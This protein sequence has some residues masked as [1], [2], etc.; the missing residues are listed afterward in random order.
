MTSPVLAL[1]AAIRAICAG[2]GA[3]AELMDPTIH[4]EAPRGDPP[5][6]ATFGDVSLRDSSTS[7]ESGHEQDFEILVWA[8]PGSAA[9][10]LAASDRIATLLDD[11]SPALAGHR[12]VA[13][14]ARA[15]EAERDAASR[16]TRIALN[17]RALT[18]VRA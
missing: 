16:S 15:M 1:R 13:L 8:K 11:A 7:T 4:D 10:G 18:E 17:L 9:S 12:L 5:V 6:Y 14:S 2:D 3:L